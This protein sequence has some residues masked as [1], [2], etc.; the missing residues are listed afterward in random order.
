MSV[1]GYICDL[2]TTRY[3][4]G[5]GRLKEPGPGEVVWYPRWQ[6]TIKAAVLHHGKEKKDSPSQDSRGGSI[7]GGYHEEEKRCCLPVARKDSGC[8]LLNYAY[9]DRVFSCIIDRVKIGL[10]VGQPWPVVR[11]S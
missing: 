8:R 6:L 11:A 9:G 3:H 7:V 10:A 5:L 1:L 2:K 4:V